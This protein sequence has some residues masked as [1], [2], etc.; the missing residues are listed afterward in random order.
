MQALTE[1]A[2]QAFGFGSDVFVASNLDAHEATMKELATFAAPLRTLEKATSQFSQDT[3]EFLQATATLMTGFPFPRMWAQPSPSERAQPAHVPAPADAAAW[4]DAETH[5]VLAREAPQAVQAALKKELQAPMQQWLAA[6]DVAQAQLSTLQAGRLNY[7]AAR[8]HLVTAAAR[9][10]KEAA[11]PASPTSQ[12]AA[13]AVATAAAAPAAVVA[14]GEEG[15]VRPPDVLLVSGGPQLAQLQE[16]AAAM[17][18]ELAEYEAKVEA[19]DDT[20]AWLA[21]GAARIKA[22]LADAAGAAAAAADSWQVP[23]GLLPPLQDR[24]S[25][26]KDLDVTVV[27]TDSPRSAEVAAAQAAS[28]IATPQA[29]DDAAVTLQPKEGGRSGS[30]SAARGTAAGGGEPAQGSPDLS[31][32]LPQD[33]AMVYGGGVPPSP[34]AASQQPRG[35]GAAQYIKDTLTGTAQQQRQRRCGRPGGSRPV[36]HPAKR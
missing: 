32:V 4:L 19:L 10:A 26:G 21:A 7:D 29:P 8:R 17:S 23:H 13:A 22:A 3:A 25:I 11:E 24:T 35:G 18:A 16:V 33:E 5:Q 20:L 36:Q 31:A 30:A 6:Y 14:G 34:T 9:A 28:G 1:R 2:R 15:A 27:M 12:T